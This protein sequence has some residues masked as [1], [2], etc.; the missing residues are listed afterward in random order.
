MTRSEYIESV[1]SVTSGEPWEKVQEG[2]QSDINNL[3]HRELEADTM[4]KIMELRGFRNALQYVH[5]LRELAKTEEA[6]ANV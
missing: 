5:D 4:E 3:I 1:Y 6:H 2:L